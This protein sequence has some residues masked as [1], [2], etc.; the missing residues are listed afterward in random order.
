L[1]W[2]CAVL[3]CLQCLGDWAVSTGDDYPDDPT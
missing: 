1:V 2:S 3:L